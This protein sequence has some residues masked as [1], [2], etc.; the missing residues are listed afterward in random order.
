[1][2]F[3]EKLFHRDRMV[4]AVDYFHGGFSLVFEI[5]ISRANEHL[6][7]WFGIYTPFLSSAKQKI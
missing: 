6:L 4:T 3:G 7:H 2:I 5:Y 1:M